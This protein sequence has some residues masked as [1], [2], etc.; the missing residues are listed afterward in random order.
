VAAFPLP[1]SPA[2][3]KHFKMRLLHHSLPAFES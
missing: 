2:P 1:P 3:R